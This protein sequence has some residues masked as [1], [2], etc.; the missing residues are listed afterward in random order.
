MFVQIVKL[1]KSHGLA[2]ESVSRRSSRPLFWINSSVWTSPLVSKGF[3]YF[4]FLSMIF[5][6]LVGYFPC[7]INIRYCTSLIRPCSTLWL[8]LLSRGVEIEGKVLNWANHW[9][10]EAQ[11]QPMHASAFLGSLWQPTDLPKSQRSVLLAFSTTEGEQR[12]NLLMY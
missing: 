7:A 11:L 9:S 8:L 2:F 12:C 5:L 10:Q 4:V 1:G 6:V 3:K